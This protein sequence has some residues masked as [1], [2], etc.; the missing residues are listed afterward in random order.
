MARKPLILHVDDDDLIAY[1]LKREIKDFE[2]V[3][4]N[5]GDQ[6]IDFLN[7]SGTFQDAPRPSLVL[8]DLHMPKKDGLQI[9]A[10]IRANPDLATIP[11]A[12]FT[13]SQRPADREQALALGAD[14]FIYKP[15]GIEGFIELAATLAKIAG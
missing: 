8:L 11:V 14:H 13:T 2:I 9:L 10:A 3:R 6:A 15:S 12:I 7:R 4:V 5:N 1:L